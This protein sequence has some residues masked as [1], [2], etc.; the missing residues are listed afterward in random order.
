[1]AKQFLKAKESIDVLE[2]GWALWT[3]IEDARS[4]GKVNAFDALKFV[5]VIP[6]AV[7]AISGI[8][9]AY[10]EIIDQEARAE[11]KAFVQDKFDIEDDAA[12]DLIE[13][14]FGW[15]LDGVGHAG[16]WVAFLRDRK[17]K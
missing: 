5:P 1:M 13:K 6:K 11:V 9:K 8:D 16:E 10:A 3:A 15:V 7:A 2:F 14:T 4:D 12:E 17:K